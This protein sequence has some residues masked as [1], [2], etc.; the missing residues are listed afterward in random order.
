MSPVEKLIKEAARLPI[1]DRKRLIQRLRASL[2]KPAKRKA[3]RT[4]RAE[5]AMRAFLSLKGHS[6]YTD[7]STNKGKHLAEVYAPKP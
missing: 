4:K 6:D 7:V 2:P 3:T 5:K 1:Q